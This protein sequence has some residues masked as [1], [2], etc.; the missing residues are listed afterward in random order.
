MLVGIPGGNTRCHLD[1]SEFH[2]C[3]F[4]SSA[5]LNFLANLYS[6]TKYLRFLTSDDGD[7]RIG[8][9]I[10]TRRACLSITYNMYRPTDAYGR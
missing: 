9:R 10:F 5:S 4:I 6:F 8:S 1:I 7:I 3:C 2:P